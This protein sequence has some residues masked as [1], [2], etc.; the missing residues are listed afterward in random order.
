M[1]D[2][3]ELKELWIPEPPSGELRERILD[4]YD[5]ELVKRGRRKIFAAIAAAALVFAGVFASRSLVT[6]RDPAPFTAAREVSPLP[7][8]KTVVKATQP[9][10]PR[11][12]HEVVT[13]FFPLM[14]A[15]PDLLH[16]LLLRVTVPA[17]T[18]R[19][20]GLPVMPEQANDPVQADLLIGD[21]G[22]TRAIRFVIFE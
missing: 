16:G 5:R 15:P 22:A 7:L 1:S 8:V 4:A 10:K 12:K 13:E 9:V 14:F 11:V 18:M 21:D 19:L 20:A 6:H 17:S 2:E 3:P